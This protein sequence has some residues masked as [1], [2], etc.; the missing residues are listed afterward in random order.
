VPGSRTPIVHPDLLGVDPPDLLVIFATSHEAEIIA[1]QAAFLES[2]GLFVSL[3][4]DEPELVGLPMRRIARG[5]QGGAQA[6]C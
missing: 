1:Q 5:K 3:R 6:W 4:G 2:G